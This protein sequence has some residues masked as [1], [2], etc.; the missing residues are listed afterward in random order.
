MSLDLCE[1]RRHPFPELA[2]DLV[3]HT[4]D[5]TAHA[6]FCGCCP[7][8]VE[9]C[10]RLLK[11]LIVEVLRC[12]GK[13]L[14]CCLDACRFSSRCPRRRSALLFG[15]VPPPGAFFLCFQSNLEGMKILIGRLGVVTSV[16]F[17]VCVFNRPFARPVA[18]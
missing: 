16:I 8:V 6:Y 2:V 14:V 3:Q 12:C 7:H 17:L 9:H 10:P 1:A 4:V 18:W 15:D 11:L 13:G 5:F